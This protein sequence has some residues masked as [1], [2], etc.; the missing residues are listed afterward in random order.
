MIGSIELFV[1]FFA[2]F[3]GLSRAHMARSVLEKSIGMGVIEKCVSPGMVALTFDD[4]V[5]DYTEDLLKILKRE[6][7]LATFFVLGKTIDP[8]GDSKWR[9]NR[10]I[11]KNIWQS[12]MDVGSHSYDHP[13]FPSISKDDIEYQMEKTDELLQ[14]VLGVS[15]TMMRLPYGDYSSEVVRFLQKMGYRII[16]WNIDSDDWRMEHDHPPALARHVDR[17]ISSDPD[18]NNYIILEHDTYRNTVANQLQI[19]KDIKR[20]GYRLV[21]MTECLG[22]E[23]LYRR[24]KVQ[25]MLADVSVDSP[26]S[27]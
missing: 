25:P 11:L 3:G 4:G 27:P 7:V 19:I 16:Q 1:V 13:S 18:N 10:Q 24:A 21:S 5:S 20:K 9:R 8:K 14:E 22:Y 6:G 15:T 26:D 17:M 12:G 2:I 23:R